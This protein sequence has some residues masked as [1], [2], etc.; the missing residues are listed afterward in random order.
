MIKVP[1][2]I[3]WKIYLELADLAKRESKFTLAAM[4]FKIVVT[5]QPFAY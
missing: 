4:I 2:K 1:T 3:L 5:I